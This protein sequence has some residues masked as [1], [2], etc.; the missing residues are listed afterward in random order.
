M[1]IEYVRTCMCTQLQVDRVK[2]HSHP[3]R[4][5]IALYRAPG[6]IRLQVSVK[7]EQAN[8]LQFHYLDIQFSIL[9]YLLLLHNFIYSVPSETERFVLHRHSDSQN[10]ITFSRTVNEPKLMQSKMPA[11]PSI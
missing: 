5:Y 2:V 10:Y 8:T 9:L 3:V 6:D 11:R 7:G 1:T 4:A